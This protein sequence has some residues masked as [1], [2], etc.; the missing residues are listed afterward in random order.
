MKEGSF[1]C[2]GVLRSRSEGC[3]VSVNSTDVVAVI[4]PYS[5][6]CFAKVNWDNLQWRYG[7][8]H[9]MIQLEGSFMLRRRNHS[10]W[11]SHQKK[12]PKRKKYLTLTIIFWLENAE[13]TATKDKRDKSFMMRNGWAESMVLRRATRSYLWWQSCEESR[14]MTK[15]KMPEIEMMMVLRKGFALFSFWDCLLLHEWS[16]NRPI[17]LNRDVCPPIPPKRKLETPK[18][19][20][21]RWMRR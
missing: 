13:A 2:C 15:M 9:C 16:V 19:P 11:P 12:D 10:L 4:S 8:K 1:W 3:R 6:H 20:K 14:C 18:S 5:P 7:D 17:R 21:W